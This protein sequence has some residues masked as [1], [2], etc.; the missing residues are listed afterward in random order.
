MVFLSKQPCHISD[1][2]LLYYDITIIIC[3]KANGDAAVAA[4][5]YIHYLE[6][7]YTS[8][9]ELT[10]E[11]ADKFYRLDDRF[12]RKGNVV[13]ASRLLYIFV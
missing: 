3:T 6:D 12:C 7:L 10:P 4:R 9:L 11:Q 5:R 8:M 2:K 1:E 13:G